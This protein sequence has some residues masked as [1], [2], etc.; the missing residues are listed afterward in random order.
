MVPYEDRILEEQAMCMVEVGDVGLPTAEPFDGIGH[1][2]YD[3]V[4]SP[5]TVGWKDNTEIHPTSTVN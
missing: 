4:I 5:V 3:Y 1:D 2:V